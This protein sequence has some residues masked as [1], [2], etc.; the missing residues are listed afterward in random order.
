MR[1]MYINHEKPSTEI[2]AINNTKSVG[3]RL[4][5]ELGMK[6]GLIVGTNDASADTSAGAFLTQN[7]CEM[8]TELDTVAD[9]STRVH[10]VSFKLKESLRVLVLI[11]IVLL[12]VMLAE[13]FMYSREQEKYLLRVREYVTSM[14]D[15]L[16][17][18]CTGSIDNVKPGEYEKHGTNKCYMIRDEVIAQGRVSEFD[19]YVAQ[20]SHIMRKV[21]KKLHSHGLCQLTNLLLLLGHE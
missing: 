21:C 20:P 8:S 18:V 3:S 5:T 10:N 9:S 19:F 12:V 4:S 17:C 11:L 15:D 1:G 16:I 6:L 14:I 7:K 13:V 2:R